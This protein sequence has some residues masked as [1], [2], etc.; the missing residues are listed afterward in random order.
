MKKKSIARIL[1]LC[2]CMLG[3]SITCWYG[4]KVLAE[5]ILPQNPTL[6]SEYKVGDTISL[7][8]IGIDVAGKQYTATPVVY[9]PNGDISTSSEYTVSYP[10]KY[11]VD[12]V[13]AVNG[14]TYKKT[15]SFQSKLS[16]FT[17]ANGSVAEYGTQTK[18][19]LAGYLSD[20]FNKTAIDTYN[21]TKTGI[22]V[23][24]ASNDRFTYN[25]VLNLE[26]LQDKPFL[27]F[28]CL[29]EEAERD[30]QFID[31]T[32]TDAYDSSISMSI[33]IST[34]QTNAANLDKPNSWTCYSYLMA[35]TGQQV[36]MG[37]DDHG[38]PQF[39]TNNHIYGSL[40]RFGMYGNRSGRNWTTDEYLT[41]SYD[42]EEKQLFQ[43][44]VA[45]KYLVCDFD[46]PQHFTSQFNGFT[47]NEV[48]LSISMRNC[49]T[50]A[51]KFVI[52]EIGDN[53]LSEEFVQDFPVPK[54]AVN[55]EESPEKAIKGIGYPIPSATATCPYSGRLEPEV[56]A[57]FAYG[58]NSQFDVPIKDGYIYPE[59]EGRYTL[60]Y[61]A[62]SV[63]GAINSE[64]VDISVEDTDYK[65]LS[66]EDL[67]N[68]SQYVGET[69]RLNVPAVSGGIGEVKTEATVK[70]GEEKIEVSKNTFIPKKAGN[71]TVEWKATDILGRSENKIQTIT[72]SYTEE[73]II[74]TAAITLPEY[75][76]KGYSYSLP[77]ATAKVYSSAGAKDVKP[78]VSVTNG[79]IAN[80]IF[81]PT[82]VGTAKIKFTAN[83]G[84]KNREVAYEIPVI[85]VAAEE[86]I[87]IAKYFALQNFTATATE[88]N[89]GFSATNALQKSK[90]EFI[91]RFIA[92]GF[93]ATLSIPDEVSDGMRLNVRLRDVT[94]NGNI[95]LTLI[96]SATGISVEYN[97]NI[98]FNFV[99]SDDITLTYRRAGNR[100]YVTDSI[101]FELGDFSGFQSGYLYFSAD[102][103]EG[104]AVAKVCISS[105]AGQGI[106]NLNYDNVRP[107]V[108]SEKD[109]KFNGEFGGTV[110]VYKALTADALNPDTQ[111]TVSVRNPNG[112][113]VTAKDGTVLQNVSAEKVYEFVTD[114]YGYYAI[115]Y[116]VTASNGQSNRET[117]SVLITDNVAPTLEI[118]ENIPAQVKCGD[119]WRV[120]QCKVT[121]NLDDEKDIT[122][123]CVISH[124]GTHDMTVA[125]SGNSFT[126]TKKGSYVVSF[127]AM[128]TSGNLTTIEYLI[129]V[130]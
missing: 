42:W 130:L 33:Q 119:V 23:N 87:D 129:T 15:Y 62:K 113:F 70:L 58:S 66:I 53:D 16:S 98:K 79:T 81:T 117:Y 97:G 95:V 76:I 75:F 109:Y 93:Y 72:I 46:N 45:G 31:I 54:L 112:D 57:Y 1:L 124:L 44:S 85:D 34:G 39:G 29:P 4:S 35:K 19:Y 61:T 106:N 25:K 105:L 91:N 122:V 123:M 111:A 126:F 125:R 121:D 60:I 59:Y 48:I 49:Y 3:C 118:S 5:N 67:E 96:K 100:M 27:T 9:A 107:D 64:R 77:S 21:V 84:N 52:T 78:D 63:S 26:E 56:K 30:V 101:Y 74:D 89:I 114:I 17:T 20:P 128:D 99:S 102:V 127:M 90:L 6:E 28:T 65:K 50:S 83:N 18:K 24:L 12:Y 40:A 47:T 14:K 2:L 71:Y 120:P 116:E 10:G 51:F 92:D 55:T 7:G 69:V 22:Y 36:Y 108:A 11:S 86:G 80:G 13:A 115:R 88:N 43:Q 68:Q 104:S 32:L 41:L 38:D 37:L 94:G 73:P 103:D 110:T 82:E 8:K